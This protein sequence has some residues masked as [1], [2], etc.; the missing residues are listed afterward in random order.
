M[1]ENSYAR[2][3]PRFFSRVDPTPVA[4]PRLIKWN[5]A[6]AGQLR[7]PLDAGR[8]EQLAGV[9]LYAAGTVLC[10]PERTV[11]VNELRV[12]CNVKGRRDAQ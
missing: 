2:L 1:F 5:E 10:Q 9:Q 4:A 12:A 7:L 11:E 3:P 8:R 6:L